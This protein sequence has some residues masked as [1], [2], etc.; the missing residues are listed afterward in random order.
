MPEPDVNSALVI[1]NAS[2]PQLQESGKRAVTV[3][4]ALNLFIF[5]SADGAQNSLTAHID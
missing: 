2:V 3:V 5:A 1:S 4:E